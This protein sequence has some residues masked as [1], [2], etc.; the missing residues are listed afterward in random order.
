MA[1]QERLSQDRASGEDQDWRLRA[2]DLVVV[3]E[4]SMV[5]TATLAKIQ[6]HVE[7]A[8]AKMLL[9]G[10]HRQLAAVGA[11][12]GMEL[13]V[14]AGAAYELTEARR[15][16]HDW[17]AAAS[18]RL[19]AGD[20]SVLEEYH[21]QGR[22]LD[23][24][25]IDEAQRSVGQA[26]LADTLAGRHCLLITDT[27]EQAGQLCAQLRS[28]FIKLGLVEEA[29][30]PLGLQGT[31]AGV[32]DLVQARRIA[33]ELAGYEGNTRG[34][35]NREQ[36]RVLAT[37][38]DGG[39]VVAPVLG[40][41]LDTG[42]QLGEKLTLPDWYVREHLALGYAAT[43][44]AT[45][46]VTVDTT[47]TLVTPRT[48]Q[49]G[50]Y[51]AMTRGR[52]ANTAHVATQTISDPEGDAPIGVVHDAIHRDPRAVL[53]MIFE[54][55]QPQRSALAIAAES[56]AQARSV[57]TAIERLEGFTTE[58]GVERTARW[59][60]ALVDHGHLSVGQRRRIAAED[61]AP[62][63]ARV[64]RRAELGGHDP[65]Q[66]LTNA[67]TEQDF[68]GARQLTNV[69]YS[70][71]TTNPRLSLDPVGDS[72]TERTPGV[73]NPQDQRYAAALTQAADTRRHELAAQAS[74]QPPPWAVEAFGPVPTDPAQRQD[75]EH[76]VGIV[77]A[78]R[79]L[80]GH[81]DP[82][83][84]IG[85]AP[86]PGLVEQYAS[87]RAC[88]RALGWPDADT[89]EMRLN[90]GQL[91]IRIRA[92]AREAAFAPP[93]VSNELAGTRQAATRARQRATLCRAEADTATDPETRANL[94]EQAHNNA[95]L[96]EDLDTR[97]TQLVEIDE[98]HYLHRAQTAMTR[99]T[100]Q[101]CEHELANRY[102]SNPPPDDATTPVEWLEA[103]EAQARRADDAYREI[104]EESDLAE[105]TEHRAAELAAF[106]MD[107]TAE[108]GPIV[109]T[110][111]PDIRD[112]ATTRAPRP[113]DDSVHVPT[114]QQ[115]ADDLARARESLAEIR[116]RQ[117]LD[118][119]HATE[120]AHSQQL[121]RWQAD[122]Q[123]DTH[124]RDNYRSRSTPADALE[125]E[126]V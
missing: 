74:E 8:G 59:L 6:R 40:R 24:G 86:K 110:A 44:Y 53:G 109:E 97:I 103:A 43:E 50:L 23:A 101:R 124:D 75:W 68:T 25:T 21:K 119:R 115:T 90:E 22:L 52:H 122:D 19:R 92:A 72:Y 120:Y 117:A 99:V 78:H 26:W 76:R 47:Q 31:Y 12:G 62:T 79:E 35:I 18:L 41:T 3:D 121:A 87:W 93:N 36:Y 28:E 113:V 20:D 48:S 63:L 65:R 27:N 57:R 37:R 125:V 14:E 64:L 116:Q 84:A 45:I 67:V 2:G 81:T 104:T 7:A 118:A 38:D 70:R 54:R 105:I 91:R 30:V 49:S 111:L 9:T 10:D 5:D 95:K 106:G 102:A 88:C 11:G 15:F 107:Y 80:S 100:G 123:A 55:D 89:E 69:L 17:E 42:E 32:G 56:A 29:G 61:G 126:G 60:D 77:A 46:G 58:L 39:L 82:T 96:A 34:P 73:D 114:L 98:A 94:L 33:R 13:V 108:Q 71:I 4:S 16:T 83:R 112:L 85:P 51:V 1:I 66:V